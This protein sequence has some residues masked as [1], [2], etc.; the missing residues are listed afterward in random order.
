MN[1]VSLVNFVILVNFLIFGEFCYFMNC[2]ER[3]DEKST[4]PTSQNMLCHQIDNILI[5]LI[6]KV[7]QTVFW[8][9]KHFCNTSVIFHFS[10]TKLMILSL[11]KSV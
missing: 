1:F 6:I 9:Q 4:H 3:H 5:N 2:L 10:F 8:K 11:S 7:Y